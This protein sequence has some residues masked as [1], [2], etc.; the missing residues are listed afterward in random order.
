MFRRRLMQVLG[1]LLLVGVSFVVGTVWHEVVGHGL[2]AVACGGWIERVEILGVQV[3]PDVRWLGG[4][5]CYGQCETHGIESPTREHLVALAGSVSTW[6]A[7]VATV[8]LLWV[9]RWNTKAGIVLAALSLWW[10][11][12]LTYTLPSWGLP[13]SVL[14]GQSHYSEPYEAAVALGMAGWAFQAL[15]ILTSALLATATVA[16]LIRCR[17][18]TPAPDVGESLTPG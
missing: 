12:L 5:E 4:I 17:R 7:A 9:R 11:D 18:R 15:A 2:T 6:L 1:G 10:I 13:R 8:V 14:W 3:Y 16:R